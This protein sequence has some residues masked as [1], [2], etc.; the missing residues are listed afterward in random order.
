MFIQWNRKK[1]EHGMNRNLEICWLIQFHKGHK[2]FRHDF[3]FFIVC[4][5]WF[6]TKGSFYIVGK[7]NLERTFEWVL[8]RMEVFL[9]RGSG[10]F[11]KCLKF[12]TWVIANEMES[13]VTL[14]PTNVFKI[15]SQNLSKP[16]KFSTFNFQ[17]FHST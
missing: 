12:V 16:C 11:G 2:F 7:F 14:V 3:R 5:G 4:F 17:Q 8:L 10:T 13:S 9:S 1:D 6:C 15:K